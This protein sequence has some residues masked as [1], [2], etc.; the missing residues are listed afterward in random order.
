MNALSEFLGIQ[1]V[2]R[3]SKKNTDSVIFCNI[4]PTSYIVDDTDLGILCYIKWHAKFF[5][6]FYKIKFIEI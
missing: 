3:D 2:Y 5:V 4:D 1:V 6:V